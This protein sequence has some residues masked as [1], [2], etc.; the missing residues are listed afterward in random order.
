MRHLVLLVATCLLAASEPVVP[1]P[2]A[3]PEGAFAVVIVP[4]L[5]AT[6]GRI[7]LAAQ[8]LSPN[9]L[10]PGQLAEQ[11]GTMIGDPGLTKLAAGTSLV[12][13]GPG[14]A[15]PNAALI[16]PS[17]DPG[18][19]VAAAQRLGMQAE[20]IGDLVA[21]GR[22][23]ADLALGKRVAKDHA[24][25]G[26]APTA[27]DLRLLIAPQRIVAAYQPVLA[28]FTTLM[29]AQ[30]AKEPNG[31]MMARI[32]G[33]EVAGLLAMAEDIAGWQIDLGVEGTV[34]A[35][36]QVLHAKAESSLA[37]ALVAPPVADSKDIA[38]RMG[39]DP[40]YLVVIGR[41]HPRGVCA[42]LADLL[43]RLRQL[44][45]GKDLIDEGHLALLS[46]WGEAVDGAFAMR[47]RAV[48][49]Q[50]LRMEGVY[51]ARDGARVLAVNKRLFTALFAA[52]PIGDL[53]R[54]MGIGMTFSENTRT[55]GSI[56]VAKVAYA[57]DA[58]KLP[59]DQTDQMRK[60]MQDI[61]L[62]FLPDALVF[63][64]A[65]EDLDR[66]VAGGGQPL[67]TAA[68][69][70]IGAGRDGY[71]D[72]DWLA[73]MKVSFQMN[74][75]K[76]AG[77]ADAVAKLPPGEPMTAAWTARDGRLLGEW[78]LPLKPFFDF[79]KA[80]QGAIQPMGGEEA[81]PAAPAGDDQVF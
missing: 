41:Y 5:R 1:T 49:D 26:A 35:F 4:D 50:P 38:A 43:V 48:G 19:Y 31:A 77:M 64:N 70:T 69:H 81:P 44:P 40:G 8:A 20:A 68:E 22:K 58:A 32:V 10:K 23:P 27:R 55:L 11:I 36:D 56:S 71:L 78:R 67:P 39:F 16:V 14:G 24:T 76:L 45:A 73:L 29:T 80:M 63:A 37:K 3:V 74:G 72:L 53:Y 46:E 47:M 2:Q 13:I 62:A 18:A 33:L 15:A 12:A 7:E 66:L 30:L 65:P 28:G 79:T 17:S 60:M 42:W 9:A 57:F 61:E 52:G 54:G 59:A 6:L 75:A 21:V 34:V 51:G 25:L